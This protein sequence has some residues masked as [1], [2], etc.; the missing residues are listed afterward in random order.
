[1]SPAEAE[2]FRFDASEASDLRLLT[3]K[4][5]RPHLPS[6]Y[7]D[8][9]R[10]AGML[11]E[12]TRRPLTV[13]S[14]GAGW[15]KTL[16]TASWAAS[17]PVPGPVAWLSLDENDNDPR[18]FWSY[19]VAAIRSSTE[20]PRGNPLAGLAPG[21][22]GRDGS[23]RRLVSGLTLLPDPVVVVLDDFQL[24]REPA[25]LA[26]ITGLL[27]HPP[28]Q[29]RLVLLTRVDPALPLRRLELR[30]ELAE[31]RS[32]D[33]AFDVPE[34]VALF[35]ADGVPIGPDDVRLLVDRTEG[36]P[37]GLRLAAYFLKG[38]GPGRTAEAFAGN[39]QAV[40]EYLLE[41]VLTSQPP[42]LQRF[43]LRTSVTDR[44][45]GGLAEALTDDPRGQRFLEQLERSN[46]FVVGLSPDRRWYRYHPML[47]EMLRHQ[48]TLVEPEIVP[49]LERRAALW[50]ASNGQPIEA[51][52]HSADA[53]DWPLL[54]RLFV[55]QAA[56]LMLSSERAAVAA[57]L[58]RVPAGRLTEEPELAVTAAALCLHA[59]RY[60]EM[61]PH[62]D[63]ARAQLDRA[64]PEARIATSIAVHTFSAAVTRSRGDIDALVADSA[65]ALDETSGPG[66]SLPVSDQYRAIAL[67]NLGTGLLWCD[68]FDEAETR[69]REGLQLTTAHRL[70]ASRIN[71]LAHL[72]LAAAV[73]GRLHE[74]AGCATEAVELVDARGW[75]P[76][77]QAATAHL[78]LSIVHLRWNNVDEAQSQLSRSATAA[79]PEPAV[80]C[81]VGLTQARLYATL[82][83]VEPAREH[84][85]RVRGEFHRWRPPVLLQR[86]LAVT[87]AEIDLAADDPTAAIARFGPPAGRQPPFDREQTCLAEALL[88]GGEPYRA[89]DILAP[90]RAGTH[91][92]T[93]AVEVWL[94][95]TLVA[96]RLGATDRALDALAR[97]VDAARRAGVRRPL[98][99]G[100]TEPLSRLLPQ[101]ERWDPDATALL[102]ELLAALGLAR[103]LTAVVAPATET[104]TDRE[105]TVLH[106]LPAMMTNAE[107]AA[108]LF[109]SVNTVKAHLKRIFQKLGVTTRRDA[110]RRARELG[111]LGR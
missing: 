97:A 104:L 84:L 45:T 35:A 89:D 111:L 5:A 76:L 98:L 68:A 105:L 4:L 59:G 78:A 52:R 79:R 80:R 99:F 20:I 1:M 103:P 106:Y 39:D 93:A 85:A 58:S 7:V 14:A 37:A 63:R 72:G 23:H 53:A 90:L 70:D 81:A 75:E 29:L 109:V 102:D 19:F 17:P 73:A 50:F 100:N 46:A 10:I 3:T 8:R 95:T 61:R 51:L 25:V 62:L 2:E 42:E 18:S 54:G 83:R 16:A 34:A 101:A 41:E 33:L 94:L 66:T 96:D 82:G 44:L 77:P 110:V 108:E 48:L 71:V 36:W 107:I 57:Q 28:A 43:L 31:I 56:P 86:W 69:L 65:A 32:R 74:G 27:R 87:E 55:T 22:G 30:G 92:P 49:D 40:S 9:P 67:S 88:A 91:D 13:V 12:G 38:A 11:D 64:G 6:T 15:G 47:R 60:Q 21:L 24:V 26:R